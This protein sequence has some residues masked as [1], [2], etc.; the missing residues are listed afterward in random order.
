MPKKWDQKVFSDILYTKEAIR[1]RHMYVSPCRKKKKNFACLNS[2]KVALRTYTV[3]KSMN[4][5]ELY[6]NASVVNS[7]CCLSREA[8]KMLNSVCK[9]CSN[10]PRNR[11]SIPN[12]K[13]GNTHAHLN[14]QHDI[15]CRMNHKHH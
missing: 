11:L 12:N 2:G 10:I 8:K 13:D 3:V 7:L 4:A 5:P 6:M 1:A 9:S 14:I 15:K